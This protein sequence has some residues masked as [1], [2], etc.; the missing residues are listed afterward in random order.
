MGINNRPEQ[1]HHRQPCPTGYYCHIGY[2]DETTVCCPSQILDPCSAPMNEGVGPH[3]MTRWYYET[4]TRKCQQ[5]T[6]KGI[7]CC[8]PRSITGSCKSFGS[9]GNR[10]L[11]S[12]GDASAPD[13]STMVFTE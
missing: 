2:D 8:D 10:T 1:C 5:F 7:F 4:Q 11:A 9:K 12:A 3:V 6:Y 13:H